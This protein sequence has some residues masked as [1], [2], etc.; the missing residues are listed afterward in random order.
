ML[1]W[2][3]YSFDHWKSLFDGRYERH[4]IV[5]DPMFVDPNNMDYRIKADSPALKLGFQQINKDKIGLKKD[6]SLNCEE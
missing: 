2:K 6:F 4:S 1:E 5:A 3:L